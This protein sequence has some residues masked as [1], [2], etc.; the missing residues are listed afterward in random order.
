VSKPVIVETHEEYY[1]REIDAALRPGCKLA[2]VLVAMP[3][4]GVIGG[5]SWMWL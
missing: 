2:M 3:L 4:L 5:V 1:S